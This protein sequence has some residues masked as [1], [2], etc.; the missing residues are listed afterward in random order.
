M[1]VQRSTQSIVKEMCSGAL[2]GG[3]AGLLISRGR[4]LLS[5]LTVTSVTLLDIAYHFD[6]LKAHVSHLTLNQPS[7]QEQ[8]TTRF[9]RLRRHVAR[10]LREPPDDLD[11]EVE[12]FWQDLR[13]HV[14]GHV[15]FGMGFALMFLTSVALGSR[16][17]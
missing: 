11:Q 6:Y 8:V 4:Y 5:Y 10:Q 16:I 1:S 9:N 7:T 13:R 12:W 3:V 14:D 2:T 17:R 15:Y